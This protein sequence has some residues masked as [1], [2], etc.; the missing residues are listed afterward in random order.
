MAGCM[1][2]SA[3]LTGRQAMASTTPH[4]LTP[5]L[6]GRRTWPA[7]CAHAWP[8]RLMPCR[9]PRRPSPTSVSPS[10]RRSRCAYA[11]P[12]GALDLHPLPHDLGIFD[13]E[14][15]GL[16]HDLSIVQQLPGDAVQVAAGLVLLPERPGVSR[17]PCAGRAAGLRVLGGEISGNSVRCCAWSDRVALCNAAQEQQ[18]AS[19]LVAAIRVLLLPQVRRA[20]PPAGLG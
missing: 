17:Q 4:G 1:K 5:L 8:R 19:Y 15:S 10:R 9:S 20:Q 12:G 16:G 11:G 7:R 13:A 3:V 6:R 18:S 2:R 14:G